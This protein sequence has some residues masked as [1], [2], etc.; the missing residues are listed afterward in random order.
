MKAL[1]KTFHT[2]GYEV[3]AYRE[4]PRYDDH[5]GKRAGLRCSQKIDHDSDDDSADGSLTPTGITVIEE[6]LDESETWQ[7]LGFHR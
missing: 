5:A 2:P 6:D 7:R 4:R 1:R 3:S